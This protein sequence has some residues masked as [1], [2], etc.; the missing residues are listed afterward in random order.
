MLTAVYHFEVSAL[1]VRSEVLGS[2]HSATFA[3]HAIT[4]ILPADRRDF[5]LERDISGLSAL[6]G[7]TQATDT[8]ISWP[9]KYL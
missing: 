8:K 4:L 5:G 3:G 1:W 6:G 7:Y 2:R 9:L